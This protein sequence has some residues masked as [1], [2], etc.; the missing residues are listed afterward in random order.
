[1]QLRVFHGS[2]EVFGCVLKPD[3]LWHSIISDPRKNMLIDIK[4]TSNESEI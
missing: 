1:M 3:G 2:V 4:N